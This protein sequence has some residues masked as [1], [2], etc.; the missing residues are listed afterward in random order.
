MHNETV[1]AKDT[2]NKV[3]NKVQKKIEK[4]AQEHQTATNARDKYTMIR[5]QY[6]ITVFANKAIF[7]SS[8]SLLVWLPIPGLS[9]VCHP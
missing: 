7:S 6:C 9:L 1:V 2:A 4:D 3:H 8:R 5:S